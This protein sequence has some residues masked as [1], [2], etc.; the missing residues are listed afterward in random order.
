MSKIVSPARIPIIILLL[1]VMLLSLGCTK[2][3]TPAVEEPPPKLKVVT[4]TSLISSIVEAI[5]GGEAK[6]AN[7]IPPAQ[8][9][10][11][12]DIGPD[13]IRM[14]SDGDLFLMHGWQGETFT[15]KLI[16]SADNPKLKVV[17]LKAKGNWMTPPVQA[18]AVGEIA[19][20]LAEV[21]HENKVLYEGKAAELKEAIQAKGNELKSVLEANGL[22]GVKAIC[23]EMQV[24]FVKW[25]G[26]DVVASYGRPDE[27]A[28][29]VLQ[30]LIDTAKEAKVHL[31]I[32][33]LQS[34]AKV[35]VGMAEEIGGATQQ[36][37][38][39]N[40]PGAFAGTETWAKAIEKN[41]TLLIEAH[42]RYKAACPP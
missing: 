26:F 10:G 34:G 3:A 31:V 8:C 11:H 12:F 20:A 24:G 9:P 6:V 40:F 22:T 32:D 35:G 25:A 39:S 18:E 23:A 4:T 37:T 15:D 30:D 17:V 19:S 42:A 41:V 13:A 36:V 28:P 33:N 5:A 21:D 16:E 14:L 2:E 38:L 7:I 27:L 29:Q 1:A